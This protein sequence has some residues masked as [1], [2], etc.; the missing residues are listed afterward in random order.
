MIARRRYDGLVNR[1]RHRADERLRSCSMTFSS[2][3]ISASH[4]PLS[5][6][7]FRRKRRRFL[8][9]SSLSPCATSQ[10]GD[11]TVRGVR[12][13]IMT[14]GIIC[15]PMGTI[16]PIL[17]VSFAY[18]WHMPAPQTDERVMLFA[19][20]EE[21]GGAGASAYTGVRR[22][23]QKP[24]SAGGAISALYIGTWGVCQLAFAVEAGGTHQVLNVP[25]C[26]VRE[27]APDRED[28]PCVGRELDWGG[29]LG[30]SLLCRAPLAT[31]TAT[32][33]HAHSP[34]TARICNSAT[35]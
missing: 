31:A 30:P 22:P 12:K 5:T 20:L 2:A 6:S 1:S 13:R 34:I 21:W 25:Y 19:L 9:A 7:I 27:H 16:Q 8:S 11:S 26:E 24:R 29:E 33:P 35:P 3:A 10:R 28:D 17:R 23:A 18:A 14:A 15:T 4:S 32:R